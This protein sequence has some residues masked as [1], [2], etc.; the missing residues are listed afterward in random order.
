MGQHSIDGDPRGMTVFVDNPIYKYGR[1]KMCH[2]VA[3]TN[4][5]LHAMADKIGINRKWFQSN[6]SH[7]HYDICK[8]KRAL[9]VANGAKEISIRELGHL[10]RQ[11][12][13]R[14]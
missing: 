9:A 1:M 11:W 4:E 10:L 5:E 2:M 13:S 8:Q 12:H 7:P 6:A 14:S 3:D